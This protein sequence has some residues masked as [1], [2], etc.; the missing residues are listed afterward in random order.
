[1]STSTTLKLALELA[2]K[3]T[4]REDLAIWRISRMSDY[5]YRL[6]GA[7]SGLVH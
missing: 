1:M 5:A 2:T 7:T 4:G 3:G 6:I